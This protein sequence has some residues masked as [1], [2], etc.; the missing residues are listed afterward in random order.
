MRKVSEQ[1]SGGD[2]QC[3]SDLECVDMIQLDK[4]VDCIL[5]ESAIEIITLDTKMDTIQT[6]SGGTLFKSNPS[7]NPDDAVTE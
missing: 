2:V 1:F 3:R 5:V 6:P 4:Q 7:N